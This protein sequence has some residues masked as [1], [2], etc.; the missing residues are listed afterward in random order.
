M[1]I[2]GSQHAITPA[3]AG[4]LR[5]GAGRAGWPLSVGWKVPL[6]ALSN[7]ARSAATRSNYHGPGGFISIGGDQI[8]TAPTGGGNV[9]GNLTITDALN[10]APNRCTFRVK[11]AVP[12]VGQDVVIT[13]GSTNSLDRLFA[14]QVL[15]V[16][17]TY[18]GSPLL[19]VFDVHAIDWTWAL[20]QRVFSHRWRGQT[21]TTIAQDILALGAPGFTAAW[22]AP[23]L[24]V[25]DEFTVTDHDAPQALTAL[26]NRL[27][28][29]WYVDYHRALHLW[30]DRDP[31]PVTDPSELNPVHPTLTDLVVDRDGS[32]LVTRV[33]VEGGGSIAH[34]DVRPGETLLPVVTASWY[35][36]A[37]GVVKAGPQRIRYTGRSLG[38]GGALVGPGASPSAALTATVTGGAGVT[39]GAHDYAVAF[40][41]ASGEALPGPRTAVVVG[42]IAPPLTPPAI[43]PLQAGPGPDPG[44]HGYAVT[45]VTATGETLLGPSIGVVVPAGVDVLAAPAPTA[46]TFGG[47]IEPGSFAY[48]VTFGTPSGQSTIGPESNVVTLVQQSLAP[49]PT[50]PPTPGAPTTGG[51]IEPGLFAYLHTHETS[52]GE[53]T[54]GPSSSA[55]ATGS[56]SIGN[57]GAPGPISNGP[58]NGQGDLTIM[59]AYDY[60]VTYSLAASASDHS[61]ETTVTAAS[62]QVNAL[63]SN[64]GGGKSSTITVTVP[65][66]PSGAVVWAHLYRRNRTTQVANVSSFRLLTSIA[67]NPGAGSTQYGDLIAD[68]TILSHVAPPGSNTAV[69][70]TNA[71]PVTVPTGPAGVLRRY[72][73]RQTGGGAFRRVLTINNNTTTSVLDVTASGS[74][75]ANPTPG[76]GATTNAI[77]VTQIPIGPAGVTKRYLYRTNSA[78]YRLVTTLN[79][80]TATTYTDTTATASLGAAPPTVNTSAAA[81]VALTQIPIGGADITGRRIYR[82]PTN[83]LEP[84]QLVTTIANNTATTYSDTLADAGLGTPAPVTATALANRVQLSAIPLGASAVTARKV[85]R[86]AAGAGALQL[87][88]TIADNATLTYLDALADGALGAGPASSDLSG[89]TQPAGQ[90]PAGSTTIIVASAAAFRSAGGWAVIGNGQQVVRYTGTTANALTGIPATGPG[91][92]V[93]TIAYNS[94]VTAAPMLLG[95][96]ASGDGAIVY[97]IPKGDDVNVWIQVD[98]AAAQTAAALL[99]TSATAGVHSGIIEDVIQDRRLS[100]TEARARGAAHLAQR[101]DLQIRIHYRCRDLNARSGRTVTVNLLAAPYQLSAQ[102]TIQSV[103]IRDFP[104]SL[105]PIVE[106]EASA[107]RVT[108]EDLLRRLGTRTD[109]TG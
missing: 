27:G 25:L 11:G 60:A 106:V 80:N 102:F 53:S 77:P 50:T 98:D 55:V 37:G 30:T 54:A 39:A 57:A 15:D 59:N 75:A 34:A 4:V 12:T 32:Q 76:G 91:A 109:P 70:T 69:V 2:T 7:V 24:P 66:S 67:N 71:I 29:Y 17:H 107:I 61:L 40:V 44:W 74:I 82:T 64:L 13:M 108:F 9:V 94:T 19:A 21:A 18:L 36:D 56:T 81:T 105:L 45:F 46:P 20:R 48:A 52:T 84:W 31:E 8:G 33:Y 28:G 72:L 79:N 104:P 63:A 58:N 99:F 97:P 26:A 78:G 89:L 73:Y 38:G 23:A 41:T 47:A 96:P 10:E 95:V 49:I 43:G 16:S 103:T 51:A 101:R 83:V 42:A 90:V 93:A 62:E 1:A 87:L 6:Y 5:S 68:A 65:Y 100:A 14:G 22:V 85:Y 3:R 92:I 86:T 88:T 35:E